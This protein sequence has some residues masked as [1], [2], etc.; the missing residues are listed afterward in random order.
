VTDQLPS[1]DLVERLR[2]KWADHGSG[3]NSEYTADLMA[4]ADE[5]DRLTR[6]LETCGLECSEGLKRLAAE[7]ER[8]RTT[9]SGIASCASCE[10]CRGAA[11]RALGTGQPPGDVP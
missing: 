10:M 6:K 8:L 5:I 4:A 7:N 9:L 2:W 11:K 1:K 3:Y